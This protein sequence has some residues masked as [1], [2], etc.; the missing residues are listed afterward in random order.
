MIRDPTQGDLYFSITSIIS[1]QDTPLTI[2]LSTEYKGNMTLDLSISNPENLVASY[3]NT[4]G[5]I[6][7]SGAENRNRT[8]ENNRKL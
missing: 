4:P 6:K 5:A 1:D 7:G 2:L 8:I 3:M